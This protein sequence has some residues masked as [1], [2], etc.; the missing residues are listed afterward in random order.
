[1]SSYNNYGLTQFICILSFLPQN[2][3]LSFLYWGFI[4]KRIYQN[5]M[6]GIPHLIENIVTT[7]RMHKHQDVTFKHLE[8][9]S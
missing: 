2:V 1:M 5:Y 4:A 6:V 3:I 8:C 9:T 7:Q